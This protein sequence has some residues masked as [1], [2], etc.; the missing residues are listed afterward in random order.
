MATTDIQPA[1]QI[2]PVHLDDYGLQGLC[3]N[4]QYYFDKCQPMG[5]S[6]MCRI[7]E[8]V[9]GLVP[10]LSSSTLEWAAEL[11]IPE[12]EHILDDFFIVSPDIPSCNLSLDMFIGMCSEV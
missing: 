1:F 3:W 8:A 5:C 7:F 11:H 2:F 9:L 6:S 10:P 12:I 4:S